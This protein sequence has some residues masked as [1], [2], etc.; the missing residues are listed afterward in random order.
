MWSRRGE[1][2]TVYSAGFLERRRV[3]S[4]AVDESKEIGDAMFQGIEIGRA[5]V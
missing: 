2:G 5:H 1:L 4:E 3:S